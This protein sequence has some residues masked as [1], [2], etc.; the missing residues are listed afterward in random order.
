MSIENLQAIIADY[1][2]AYFGD[3]DKAFIKDVIENVIAALLVHETK[4]DELDAKIDALETRIEEL[5]S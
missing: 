1:D 4:I 5:E 3:S 2:N